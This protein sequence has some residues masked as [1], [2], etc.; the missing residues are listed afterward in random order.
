MQKEMLQ[1]IADN[2]L[3]PF[4]RVKTRTDSVLNIFKTKDAKAVHQR[5]LGKISDYFVFPDTS[6]LF[7][8]FSFSENF[9][10]IRKRQEFFSKIE[11]TDNLFLKDLVVPR[12][13]WKPKYDLV[14]VTEDEATLIELQKLNCPVQF[15]T[16]PE[17]CRDLE[18]YEVV[19][20]VECEQFYDLLERLPQTVF[21]KSVEDVYLERY[22]TILSGWKHNLEILSKNS[23][24]SEVSEIINEINPLFDL[25]SGQQK[26]LNIEMMKESL[27]M[28]NENIFCEIKKMTVSGDSLISI[29]SKGI[30]KELQGII[31]NEI[32]K[33]GIPEHLFNISIP[34][35]LDEKEVDNYIRLRQT[36]ENTDKSEII[37]KNS[38]K[39]K[40]IPAKLQRISELLLIFDFV[41]GVSKFAAEFNGFPS[42]SEVFEIKNSKNIFL[43]GAQPISFY[44]DNNNRCSI[45][46]GANSGGKTTLIEHVIQL[47]SLF[48]LGMK[49]SGEIKMPIFSEIYYFAKNK[50]SMNKGAFETLLTQMSTIKPGEKTLILADEIESVTE[51]GVAG[52]VICATAEYFINKN[53]FL[54]IATHLG[55]EIEKSLPRFARI[56]GIE[57]K[58]LDENFE[59][60]VDHNPVLGRLAHSTPELI[61]EKMANSQKHDYFIFINEK[62][63][64][65]IL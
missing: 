48:Q 49:V 63:K 65:K 46:T 26:I 32:Q 6:S 20:V 9:D 42:Y 51:P 22:L 13:I 37:K 10:E 12:A 31:D 14:V 45:L 3:N 62:L 2:S 28:I 36:N 52:N 56:D 16:S 64:K 44:L 29:L 55:R 57:A 60:I 34:L 8:F 30:P 25:M 23:L 38:A 35:S 41:S 21:I 15:L 11:K 27:E 40:A 47:I 53:C 18:R 43:D 50:G 39:L 54:I 24:I 61:V 19:Q 5:V 1:F 17:D 33:S 59:L 7:G 4:N 58:G